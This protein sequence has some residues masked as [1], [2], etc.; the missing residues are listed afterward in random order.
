MGNLYALD[1]VALIK[2]TAGKTQTAPSHDE[3]DCRPTPVALS[4]GFHIRADKGKCSTSSGLKMGRGD[5][6]GALVWC[7]REA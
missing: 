7:M 3:F 4:A 6:H 5:G 2:P 1:S